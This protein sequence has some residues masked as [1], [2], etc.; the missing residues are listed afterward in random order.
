MA[1]DMVAAMEGTADTEAI[2]GMADTATVDMADT[3]EAM[4]VTGAT[5]L[6]KEK[7]QRR[8]A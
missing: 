6:R 8:S 3:M 7:L 2:L 5:R 4:A 1:E